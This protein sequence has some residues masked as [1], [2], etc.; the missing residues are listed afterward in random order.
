MS[1]GSGIPDPGVKKAPIPDLGSGSATYSVPIFTDIKLKNNMDWLS[2]LSSNIFIKR[3]FLFTG[4]GFIT[5]LWHLDSV[6]P[7]AFL[8]SPFLPR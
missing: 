1:L 6:V 2:V 8:G 3:L 7:A 5:T 4:I